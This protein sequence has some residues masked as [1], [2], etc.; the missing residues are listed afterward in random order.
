MNRFLKILLWMVALLSIPIGFFTQKEHTVFLWH[1]IPLT[2]VVIG[3]AGT[4][5]LILLSR[6]VAFISLK[7]EDYYD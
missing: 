3:V 5:V 4:L 7:K 2:E 6:I 1:K